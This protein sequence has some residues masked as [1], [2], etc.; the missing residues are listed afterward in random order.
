MLDYQEKELILKFLTRNYPV[1][2]VKHNMRFKRCI[3]FENNEA[4]ILSD[5]NSVK[6]LHQKLSDFLRI[7][8][9]SN[10]ETIKV[11]LNEFLNLK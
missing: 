9:S 3:L 11:V 10:N 5:K 4:F 8:F 1:S 6:E 7:I 2:R